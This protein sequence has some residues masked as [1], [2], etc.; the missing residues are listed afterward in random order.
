MFNKSKIAEDRIKEA[1]EI[2]WSY[3]QVDG[4]HHKAWVIDQMVRVLCGGEKEY[5]EWIKA[6][7]T[8]VSSEE[9]YEW[10]SGIAP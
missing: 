9:Y 2:A 7:E 6:Y 3:A 10:D 8:P 5:I 1:L 4:A